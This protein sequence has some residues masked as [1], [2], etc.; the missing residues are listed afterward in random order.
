MSN[1]MRWKKAT[2]ISIEHQ[3]KPFLGLH[4]TIDEAI[5]NFYNLFET[6]G[7]DIDKFENRRLFPAMDITETD[8]CFTVEVEMPGMGEEDIKITINEDRLEIHGEKSTSKKH[9]DKK[10]VSREITFGR[11]DRSIDL[12]P[13]VDA[14]KATATFKKGMLWVNIPK[15]AEKKN[16]SREVKINKA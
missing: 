11:Y 3:I 13:S 4:K 8:D 2:P 16:H 6:G 1:L 10:Y 7:L 9:K 5:D 15:K 12:P 14:S